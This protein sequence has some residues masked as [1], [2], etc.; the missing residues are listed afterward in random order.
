MRYH[1]RWC[2]DEMYSLANAVFRGERCL[3][4]G[5]LRGVV[6]VTDTAYKSVWV[7]LGT[8]RKGLQTEALGR[9]EK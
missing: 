9:K 1:T 7:L 2:S 5:V 3:R 4:G 8:V 6:E